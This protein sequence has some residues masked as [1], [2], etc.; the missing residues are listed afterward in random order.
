M[1]E[2]REQDGAECNE[3][4]QRL[5]SLTLLVGGVYQMGEVHARS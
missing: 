5:H 4:Q 2:N 3:A 1:T